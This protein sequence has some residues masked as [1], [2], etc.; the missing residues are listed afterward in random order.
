MLQE[1]EDYYIECFQPN[2]LAQIDPS[3]IPDK[4]GKGGKFGKGKFAKGKPK[5]KRENFDKQFEQ[6]EQI[7]KKN[8]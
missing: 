2:N 6:I 4:P 7:I 5:R 8:K 3:E 1:E